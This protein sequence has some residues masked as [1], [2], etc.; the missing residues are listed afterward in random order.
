MTSFLLP[1]STFPPQTK[2]APLSSDPSSASL[3]LAKPGS[4]TW[5]K[6][7]QS[8]YGTVP[9]GPKTASGQQPIAL[10][11]DMVTAFKAIPMWQAAKQA[12]QE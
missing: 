1:A 12:S 8:N 5:M 9:M 11:Y 3:V 2:Q 7:F 10:D 6:W 4:A